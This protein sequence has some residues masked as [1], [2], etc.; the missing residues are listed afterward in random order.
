MAKGELTIDAQRRKSFRK[1]LAAGDTKAA[2]RLAPTKY[3]WVPMDPSDDGNGIEEVTGVV[4]SPGVIVSTLPG[5]EPYDMGN[6]MENIK[7]FVG[8]V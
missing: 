5:E 1:A 6:L 7:V 3:F 2:A 8:Y 4:E